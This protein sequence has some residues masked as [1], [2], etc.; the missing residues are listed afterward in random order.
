MVEVNAP[1][2]VAFLRVEVGTLEPTECSPSVPR[3]QEGL[4]LSAP[5]RW[6]VTAPQLPVCAIARFKSERQGIPTFLWNST[7]LVV[8]NAD[9]SELDAGMMGDE[10]GTPVPVR[11]DPPEPPAPPD[12]DEIVLSGGSYA[13]WAN[14]D[15]FEKTGLRPRLGVVYAFITHAGWQSNTVRIELVED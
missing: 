7:T 13:Q 5:A 1:A 9:A 15:L 12:D 3:D 8:V 2:D 4:G 10:G 11:P 14:V 6:P